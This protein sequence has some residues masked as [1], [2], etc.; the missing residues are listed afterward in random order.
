MKFFRRDK[1]RKANGSSDQ[2]Y[3]T[4][5]SPTVP[6][7]PSSQSGDASHP[8]GGTGSRSR[9][10]GGLKG[11]R[12]RH[13]SASANSIA[14]HRHKSS[15]SPVP[16][17]PPPGAPARA[18]LKLP[19]PVLE[20][21]FSLVCP[22]SQDRSYDKCEDSG[23]DSACMLCDMRDLA[24]CVQVCRRWR[25]AAERVLYTSVRIDAVHYCERED[26]L[27]ERR[28]RRSFFDRNA[29]PD[30]DTADI[31]LKLLSRTLREHPDG[32]LGATVHFLKIPYMLRES[33]HADIARTVSLLPNL[34]Y[35][36]LP[37]GL[38]MDDPTYVTLKHEIQ[39]RCPE[40]RKMTYMGGS[41]RSLAALGSGTIW[42]SLEVL[43]LVR[44]GMDPATLRHVLSALP[45][46]RALKVTETTAGPHTFSDDVLASSASEYSAD[47]SDSSGFYQEQNGYSPEVPPL[48]ELVLT[49]TLGLTA[50]GLQGYL[51]RPDA[52]QALKVLTVSGTGIKPWSLQVLLTQMPSLRHLTIVERVTATLPVAA[53][54]KEIRPL[55]SQSLRTLNY[56]I[57]AA[58]G[59]SPYA[60]IT[61]SYYNY[62]SGSILSGGLPNLRAVY[63]CDAQFPDLLL[64]GSALP[65]PPGLFGA[66]SAQNR[67]SSAG[68]IGSAPRL[69]MMSGRSSN[70]NLGL[71]YASAN[72]QSPPHSPGLRQP[73][74]LQPQPQRQSLNPFLDPQSPFKAA[75][76]PSSPNPA[77]PWATGQNPRFSSNNPFAAMISPQ[78]VRTLEVFTKG[79]DDLDWSSFVVDGGDAGGSGLGN[80][81]RPTSSYGLGADLGAGAGARKSVL[82]HTGA[83]DF[84]AVPDGAFA[85]GGVGG[86]GMPDN[87][88]D[89]HMD[90][91][92]QGG[93]DLWPRPRSSAGDKKNEKRDLWR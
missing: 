63:V 67:P 86:N 36:D 64:L 52:R 43:E 38:F 55:V 11:F 60:G 77:K 88:R 28:K 45:N 13:G 20:R 56:E 47:A 5:N 31:R 84:L 87:R 30:E 8:N 53:G 92:G 35:V 50:A 58:D 39:A 61:R 48:E 82:L 2:Q 16:I 21:I 14:H 54:T 66:P 23:S 46:L 68:S 25:V 1:Q 17:P 29:E 70:S 15:S 51:S 9:G 57:R 78:Q 75:A 93:A 49:D 33:K 59:V 71:L 79:D 42:P 89:S 41:E 32:R 24:H 44:I 91:N 76:R 83:G 26:D 65:P 19:D 27:A 12:G 4:S 80:S 6:Q 74:V 73:P 34:R 37:E 40:L 62:L 22:H 3:L 85:G 69:S 81:E 10:F 7:F 72:M 90:R 18:L